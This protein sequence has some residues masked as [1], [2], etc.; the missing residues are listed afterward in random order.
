MNIPLILNFPFFIC[1]WGLVVIIGSIILVG[2][3]IEDYNLYREKSKNK[4]YRKFH[5]NDKKTINVPKTKLVNEAL[6]WCMNYMDYPTGHKYYPTIKIVYYKMKRSRY[7]DYT[8]QTRTI[9]IFINQHE[10]S[11]S[12]VNTVIHEYVHY[13]QMPTNQQHLQYD[14]L[15]KAKGYNNHPFELEANSIAKLLS[16]KCISYLVKIGYLTKT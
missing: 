10:S 14:R 11:N 9:R 12:I 3:F 16:P 15:L 2:L 13:I 8:S 5:F 1:G 7:G 6:K 4:S